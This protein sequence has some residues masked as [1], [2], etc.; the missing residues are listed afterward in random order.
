MFVVSVE[1]CQVEVSVS[2]WSLVQRSLIDCGA[3]LFVIYKPQKWGHGPMGAF[4]PRLHRKK[5]NGRR[6][7]VRN[8]SLRS[9]LS[10]LFVPFLKFKYCPQHIV[11]ERPWV[12]VCPLGLETR[13]YT[14]SNSGWKCSSLCLCL[15]CRWARGR[16]G[17]GGHEVPNWM[18]PDVTRNYSSPWSRDC[19]YLNG[20]T[21]LLLC[22]IHV[23]KI[24]K[25]SWQLHVSA[26]FLKPS[27]GGDLED[28]L[29]YNLQCFQVPDLVYINYFQYVRV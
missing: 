16:E 24:I 26:F 11:M 13:F 27:S 5:L 23:E 19:S 3:S 17:G 7:T 14:H 9:F 18:V 12:F 29:I 4:G 25:T 20:L 22:K 8:C 21:Q 28:F 15:S 6:Y 10:L 1:C 2:S